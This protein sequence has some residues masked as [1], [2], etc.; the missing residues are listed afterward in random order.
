MQQIVVGSIAHVARINIC[1]AGEQNSIE[2][3]K[4]THK[5]FAMGIGRNYNRHTTRLKNR[6]IIA[7]RQRAVILTEV[8]GNADERPKAAHRV[9]PVQFSVFL[10]N[11]ELFRIHGE[12]KDL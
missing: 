7:T 5:L 11:I 3:V 9:F 8:P 6:L 4:G 12:C 2:A 10:I 1:T